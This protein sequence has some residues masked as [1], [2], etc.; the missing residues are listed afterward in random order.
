MKQKL[1]LCCSLIHDP[2]LLILDEP[3][4]GVDPLSRRQFW[5]LIDRIRMR[6]AHMS[7][8]T[9]TAYMEE[10]E[11]F[12]HLVA[13]DAGKILA[14]GTSAELKTQPAARPSKKRSLH[15][16]RSERRAATHAGESAATVLHDGVHGNR[17]RGAD[18][19]V[20][21]FH[22]RR[23]RELRRSNAARSS[24]SS[25]RTAAARSTTMKMLTGLLPADRGR[26]RLFGKPVDAT[27]WRS[28]G[29]SATCRRRSR[30]MPN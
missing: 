24:V 8:I 19:A 28:A 2:D 25:D 15:C 26:A 4:T 21:R 20:R 13:M 1:S 22:C 6:R 14:T 16:C 23:P 7:V 10:A 18:H 30:S 27:T 9:A 5:Q 3:T 17:G 11:R 12:D 29:A